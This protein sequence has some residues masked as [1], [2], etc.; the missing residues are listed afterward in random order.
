[1]LYDILPI[2]AATAC[3]LIQRVCGTSPSSVYSF[4]MRSASVPNAEATIP[5]IPPPERRLPRESWARGLFL[6]PPLPDLAPFDATRLHWAARSAS[7]EWA[8]TVASGGQIDNACF[9]LAV[10]DKVIEQCLIKWR[11]VSPTGRQLSPVRRR[12]HGRLAAGRKTRW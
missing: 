11:T 10:L 3:S 12:R 4:S 8:E 9:L 1:M 7:L 6:L 2:V 5:T